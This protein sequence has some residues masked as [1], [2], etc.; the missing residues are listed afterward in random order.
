MTH[1]AYGLIAGVIFGTL[2]AA[3]MLPLSF[4]DKRAA[5]SAAFVDRFAIGL[6][7][8]VVALPW[9]G[10]AIGLVF[11]VLLSIPSAI[12]TKAWR[13]IIGLG[14]VG[15]VIIGALLPRITG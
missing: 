14:A 1:L 9:P 6:V 13:P 2:A 8:G 15:G 12:I 7:I 11:G 5:I 10:W 3:S 4:P